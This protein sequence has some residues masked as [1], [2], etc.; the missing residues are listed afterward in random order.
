M[1]TRREFIQAAAGA[2]A[3]AP[4][5][6][7]AAGGSN[8]AEIRFGLIGCGQRG[9]HFFHRAA[10]VCDPDRE[11]LADAAK[12][13]GL[14]AAHAVTDLRRILD[15]RS[16]DAVVIAAP[17]HWHAPA[18]ILACEAGKHVYVEKPCSHNFRESQLLVAAARRNKVVVQHGTQ[19]RSRPF[20]IDAIN[21]L[22]EG[23]I[24]EVLMAKAWNV[25]LRDNIGHAS[26][27]AP[28]PQLDYELYVGPAE[29]MPFQSNRF[30]QT[31]RWWYNFG[32]GDLGNDGAHELDYARWGLGVNALP[33][34]IAA[35]GGKYYHDDDQQFPDTATCVFEYPSADPSDGCKQLIFEM[36]LWSRNYPHNCD[37][38]VE[39]YGTGGTM[40][41]SKRGKLLV[42]DEDNKLQQSIRPEPE[43][44]LAHLD[45]FLS[46]IRDG[47]RPSADILEG[48]RSAALA[49]LANIAIRAGRSLTFDPAAERILDD[50]DAQSLLSRKYRREGHWAIP[51]ET[52]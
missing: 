10:Y 5:A 48:H 19:Q 9:R 36:R 49:H 50:E 38:G 39:F 40:I 29:M 23:V 17:D 31:W 42:F 26:P 15:D 41:L 1:P 35:I 46:A 33:T 12:Q 51:A 13:A 22:R 2:A 11:H 18:A 30:H 4:V 32:T 43:E 37:S 44:Q 25:Q 7:Y 47:V 28:P 20:A 6:S 45:N 27:A 14:D 8:A 3:L 52:S 16:I 24:G 21:Q 34:K